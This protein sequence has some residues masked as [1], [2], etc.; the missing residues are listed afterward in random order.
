M[1]QSIHLTF[2]EGQ[3]CHLGFWWMIVFGWGL[4]LRICLSLVPYCSISIHTIIIIITI[5]TTLSELN[6]LWLETDELHL[7]HFAF[8]QEFRSGRG[9]SHPKAVN[10]RFRATPSWRKMEGFSSKISGK[11]ND[12]T[13]ETGEEQETR[14]SWIQQLCS[15]TV[16]MFDTF[17]KAE[18]DFGWFWSQLLIYVGLRMAYEWLMNLERW[19]AS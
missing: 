9:K 3:A 17:C 11:R 15:T 2:F 18:T 5:T 1:F 10:S 7:S 12:E 14:D 8:R 19:V 6:A 16:G 4:G 13:D